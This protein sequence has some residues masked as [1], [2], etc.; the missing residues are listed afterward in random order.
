MKNILS[1]IAVTLFIGCKATKTDATVDYAKKFAET[2]TQK[3][4][5]HKHYLLKFL[6]RPG[7]QNDLR[8]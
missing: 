8:D 4:V 6:R 2:I 3:E 5:K 7:L 1:I